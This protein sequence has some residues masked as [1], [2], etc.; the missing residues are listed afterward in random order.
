MS[1]CCSTHCPHPNLYKKKKKRNLYVFFLCFILTSKKRAKKTHD[2]RKCVKYRFMQSLDSTYKWH[3][4]LCISFRFV[5]IVVA[6][7]AIQL[8]LQLQHRFNI[9]YSDGAHQSHFDCQ[10]SS[11]HGKRK[12]VSAYSRFWC[13]IHFICMAIALLEQPLSL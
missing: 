10:C 3:G 12:L 9:T 6:D 2:Q 7:D 1:K 4:N 11:R 8:L 13:F 5:S